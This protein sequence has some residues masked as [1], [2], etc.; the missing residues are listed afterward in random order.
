MYIANIDLT[1]TQKGTEQ[2]RTELTTK[3]VSYIYSIMES[4]RKGIPP[5]IN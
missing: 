3:H 4:S 2:N 1:I 5:N